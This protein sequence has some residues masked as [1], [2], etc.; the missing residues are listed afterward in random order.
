MT[1]HVF[2]LPSHRIDL[3]L[4]SQFHVQIPVFSLVLQNLVMQTKRWLVDCSLFFW[5]LLSFFSTCSIFHLIFNKEV[6]QDMDRCVSFYYPFQHSG[7]FHFQD[8][9]FSSAG[10]HFLLLFLWLL[11]FP[12]HHLHC[13]LLSLLLIE[14]Y[15]PKSVLYAF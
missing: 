9:S 10:E 14:H 12:F 7:A 4:C 5:K 11:I 3:L 8:S 2:I 6:L 15:T 1:K 13:F